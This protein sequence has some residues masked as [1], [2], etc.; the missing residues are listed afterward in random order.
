M[1]KIILIGNSN[2][3][4]IK[5]YIENSDYKNLI[6]IDFLKIESNLLDYISKTYSDLN[7]YKRIKSASYLIL[8]SFIEKDIY[9]NNC[10]ELFNIYQKAVFYLYSLN[11]SMSI[12]ISFFNFEEDLKLKENPYMFSNISC[13]KILY[14]KIFNKKQTIDNEHLEENIRKVFSM[15]AQEINKDL[16]E[17]N[18][19]KLE[20]A[21]SKNEKITGIFKNKF[22]YNLI[23]TKNYD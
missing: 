17:L 21:R 9:K 3:S 15:N 23:K 20:E 14:P 22:N 19:K 18:Q 5:K 4:F 13:C 8:D 6:D 12:F 10:S 16:V 1:N 11:P 2:I 7:F